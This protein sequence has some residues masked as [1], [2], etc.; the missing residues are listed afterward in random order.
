MNF[1][2]KLI[3]IMLKKI[4]P[5]DLRRTVRALEVFFK[6]RKKYNRVPN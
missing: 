2:K 3:L 5:A 6:E 4:N 1:S